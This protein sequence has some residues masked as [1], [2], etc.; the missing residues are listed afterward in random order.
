MSLRT[1]IILSQV[2]SSVYANEQVSLLEEQQ[3]VLYIFLALLIGSIYYISNLFKKLKDTNSYLQEKTKELHYSTERLG[4]ALKIGNLGSWDIEFS[5]EEIIVN[6]QWCMVSGYKNINSRRIPRDEWINTIH[7]DDR[8]MVLK[9]GID[10]KDG[11]IKHYNLEYRHITKDNEMIW[12]LSTGSIVKRDRDGYPLRMVGI[13]RDITKD[14]LYKE[15]L[16]QGKIQAEETTRMKSEFLANMSHEI[17]TPLNAIIGFIDVLKEEETNSVK[18]EYLDIVSSSS[19]SLVY[20]INDILDFSKIESGNLGIEDINFASHKEFDMAKKL[21]MAKANEKSINLHIHYKDVPQ[22]LKGDILRIKQIINNLLSNAIKFTSQGK[23]ITLSIEYKNK[24]LLVEVQDEGVGIASSKLDGIFEAFSQEDVSTSRKYGGTGLGL[25]ISS[26]LVQLL[27]GQLKVKSTLGTGSTF[28]FTIPIERGEPVE[29]EVL[30]VIKFDSLIDKK[31]LLV[32]D[33]LINQKIMQVILNKKGMHMDRAN[34][35]LE[36]IAM[37][38]THTYDCILMDENMPNMD[39]LE[40]TREIH[41]YQR[42]KQLKSTPIIALTGNAVEGDKERLLSAGMDEYLNKP[43][44]R[45]TLYAM[46]ASL[47]N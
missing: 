11:L 31:I 34:D 35:G 4:L 30:N 28:Y 44:D 42:E 13:V 38:K 5:K 10:Y 8:E 32:E 41:K 3:V 47:T 19:K 40:A 15:H 33:N 2:L 36:A 39:G 24:D 29:Q 46:I 20:I 9:Y 25:S 12:L 23:N 43:I 22:Y 14:K 37:F 6:P 18:L 1:I 26:R 17:R 7:P 21:F 16:K 27:G 45:N